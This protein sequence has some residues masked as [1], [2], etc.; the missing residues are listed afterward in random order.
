MKNGDHITCEIKRLENGVLYINPSYALASYGVDW[1]EVE[2]VESKDTYT[3][4]V[5]SGERYT[6]TI[7]RVPAKDEATANFKI[8]PNGSPIAV[9][10]N[11]VVTVRPVEEG[12]WEQQTGAINAGFNFTQGNSSAQLQIS[13]N[14]DYRQERWSRGIPVRSSIC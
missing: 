4:V 6:G 14:T 3:V 10:S 2:R 11:E 13:G 5:T 12:F 7:E 1:A 8:S 9:K